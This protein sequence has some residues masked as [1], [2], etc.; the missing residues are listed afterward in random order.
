VWS[1]ILALAP[2]KMASQMMGAINFEEAAKRSPSDPKVRQMFEGLGKGIDLT[3]MPPNEAAKQRPFVTPQVWA[4]YSAYSSMVSF[5]V[6]QM[7]TLEFGLDG[8]SLLKSEKVD[9]LVK[10]ALPHYE[11]Y[12]TDF[13]PSGYHLLLDELEEKLLA[14]LKDMLEGKEADASAIETAASILRA[15]ETVQ[16]QAAIS[17][18]NA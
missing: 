10:T 16:T 9:Q 13:G 4:Y 7:K 5:A 8:R 1:G 12:V 11:K 2:F 14:S 6:M 15:A 3:K 17:Q 18:P